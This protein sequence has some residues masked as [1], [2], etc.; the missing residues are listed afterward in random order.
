LK[1]FKLFEELMQM[2][3]LSFKYYKVPDSFENV[4][5][6]ADTLTFTQTPQ[7]LIID[8]YSDAIVELMDFDW[9]NKILNMLTF[10]NAKVIISA[11]SALTKHIDIL[12]QPMSTV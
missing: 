2:S 6:L 3:E 12:G 5:E 9:I 7:K 10:E 8:T 11:K 4:C 1:D